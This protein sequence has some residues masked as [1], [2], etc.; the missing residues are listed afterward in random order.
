MQYPRHFL[1]TET[2]SLDPITG[3]IIDLCIIT[4]RSP[5]IVSE[6]HTKISPQNIEFADKKSIEINGY[7]P[8]SWI[9]APPFSEKAEEIAKILKK[10]V[11]IGHNVEFDL[12]FLKE[13]LERAG[14]YRITHKK[15]DTI[16]LAFEHLPIP[17]QSMKSIRIF[18]G[19]SR[20]GEHT[21]RKDVL[22]CVM[23]FKTLFRCPWYRRLYYR[24]I[25][26]NNQRKRRKK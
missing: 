1:D 11:I 19:W 26:W 17:W 16:A 25:W 23:L 10:G 8:E 15:F 6:F 9:G 5:G 2:T 18:F 13:E 3:E 7:T 24:W 12:R 22:D 21:A 20:S 4:H 14:K